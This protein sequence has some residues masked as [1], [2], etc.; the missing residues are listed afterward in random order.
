MKVLIVDDEEDI[1]QFLSYNF[2]K[3]GFTVVTALNGRDG[4]AIAI[5]ELPDIIISDI[6]M[7]I[8]TGDEMYRHI[9]E[10]SETS[11]IPFVFLTA[12]NDDYEVLKAMSSG[13]DQ[14]INKPIAP[15]YLISVINDLL[16]K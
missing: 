9:K 14:F 4:L 2:V 13:A 6:L 3:E 8:M 11:Q 1:L 16:K 5:Q 12:V 10:N 7:P 15:K